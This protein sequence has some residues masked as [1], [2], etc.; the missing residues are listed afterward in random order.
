MSCWNASVA[1]KTQREKEEEEKK[2]RT[3]RFYYNWRVTSYTLKVYMCVPC[4]YGRETIVSIG[5]E[6]ATTS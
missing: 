6:L 2:K 3:C 1:L 5:S 4:K